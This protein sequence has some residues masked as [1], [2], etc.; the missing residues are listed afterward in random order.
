M[1]TGFAHLEQQLSVQL[2][3]HKLVLPASASPRSSALNQ[4]P[5]REKGKAED[6]GRGNR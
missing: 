2:W 6:G 3:Q 5:E 4:R 1:C